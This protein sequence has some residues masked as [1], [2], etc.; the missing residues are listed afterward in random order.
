MGGRVIFTMYKLTPIGM[1]GVDLRRSFRIL[2]EDPADI[3]GCRWLGPGEEVARK[4]GRA[5]LTY[6]E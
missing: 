2:N 6:V 5:M 4:L 1:T 3:V